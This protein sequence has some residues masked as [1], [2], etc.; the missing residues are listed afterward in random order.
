MICMAIRSG[1]AGFLAISY[2]AF[3]ERT[4]TS[5]ERILTAI[6]HREP[7]R[8]PVDLGSSTVTGISAIAYNKLREKTGL[9]SRTR[10]YDVVQ[11]LALVEEP[12]LDAFSVDA[13]DLNRIILEDIEWGPARLADG[14]S[15]EHPAWFRTVQDE[16]GSW[17]THSP[18]GKVIARMARTGTCFDQTCFPWELGY[19]SHM[20]GIG[21]A[22][23]E[24]SWTALS[25]SRYFRMDEDAM[26]TRA[27][28]LRNSTDRAIVM[29]GGVKLLEL[30]FFLRRMDRMLMDLLA[31]HQNVNRLFDKL[32][33]LHLSGLESKLQNVGDLVDVIRFGDDLGMGTGPFMDLDTFRKLLKPRYKELCDYVKQRSGLKIF[34][35]SCGSIR[36]FIPDLI[37]AGFDILNPV[38]TNARGMDAVELKKEFGREITFWGGGVDTTSVLPSSS[39][40]EV[41]R[42]VLRRCE[43]LSRGG[44]FVFAPIHNILPEVP[45]ENILAAYRAVQEFNGS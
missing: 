5:R 18:G 28:Q 16:D 33:A 37:E 45:P 14:S 13:L 2:L 30:G 20:E 43:I 15:A 4:M 35:H 42:D 40:E 21:E 34:L 10:I 44:G 29:S 27:G 32:V 12:V 3:N 1:A 24:I 19:P 25:H 7:D 31:D 11:Q 26:R 39:P 8:I 22:F 17:I 23:S 38:Q 41:R 36:S 9:G 6:A